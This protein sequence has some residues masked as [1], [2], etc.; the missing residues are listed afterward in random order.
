MDIRQIVGQNVAREREKMGIS[1][2]ELGFRADLHRTYISG[3]ERGIRNPTVTVLQ[4]IAD[5]LEVQVNKLLKVSK[6][7]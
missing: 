3:V 6:R 5:A 4:K 2:E 1:Q 7:G